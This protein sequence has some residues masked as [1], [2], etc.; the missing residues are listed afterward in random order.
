MLLCRFHT[1]RAHLRS[2]AISSLARCTQ[3]LWHYPSIETWH[4]GLHQ[5]LLSAVLFSFI[6][7]CLLSLFKDVFIWEKKRKRVSTHKTVREGQRE[8]ENLKQTP[9]WSRSPIWSSISPPQDYVLNWNQE[10]RS[11]STEPP[12]HTFSHV[13]TNQW[14]SNFFAYV[15]SKNFWNSIYFFKNVDI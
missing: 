1:H 3:I 11:Q 7:A 9:C 15:L 5:S 2:E 4:H 10:V 8:R 12:R 13:N 14:S 6:H